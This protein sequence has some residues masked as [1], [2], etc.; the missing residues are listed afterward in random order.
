MDI[1]ENFRKGVDVAFSP[2]KHT[3]EH[4]DIGE[5]LGFYY[6]FTIISLIAAVVIPIIAGIAS[7][8]AVLGY[9]LAAFGAV[10]L[11]VEPLGGFLTA[12]MMQFFGKS[13]F[14]KFKNSYEDSYTATIYGAMPGNIFLWL[15]Y[16]I[17]IFVPRK[18][19]L[20]PDYSAGLGIALLIVDIALSIWGFIVLVY[21]FANQQKC[22][23]L[24]VIG[25]FLGMIAIFFAIIV[26]LIVIIVLAVLTASH[27]A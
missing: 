9:E 2:G 26:A 12:A 20:M 18:G 4:M 7:K 23:K 14:K 21:S 16:T 13:V 24:A 15:L 8:H 10:I 5:A 17:M 6:K 25:V 3:E 22:S 27:I 19:F 1:L 11:L